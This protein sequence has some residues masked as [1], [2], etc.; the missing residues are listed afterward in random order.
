MLTNE[1]LSFAGL[2]QHET[3]LTLRSATLNKVKNN[4]VVLSEVNRVVPQ[5]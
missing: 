3:I 2:Q 4:L 1:Y 5:E